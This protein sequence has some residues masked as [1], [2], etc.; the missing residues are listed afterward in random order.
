MTRALAD[1][2]VRHS[3]A[4]GA[5]FEVVPLEPEHMREIMLQDSQAYA[6]MISDSRFARPW[7]PRVRATPLSWMVARLRASAFMSC[8]PASAWGGES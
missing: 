2:D 8:T 1:S 7:R 5:R 3:T 4:K 6:D